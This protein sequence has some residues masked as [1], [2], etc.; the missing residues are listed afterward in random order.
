[1]S[2]VGD[3]MA[4]IIAHVLQHPDGL[5]APEVAIALGIDAGTARVYLQR[6]VDTGRLARIGRGTYAPSTPV[7]SVT[8]VT[9]EAPN[10]TLVT[11]VTPP[12]GQ[13]STCGTA[14]TRD[15]DLAAGQCPRCRL[16]EVDR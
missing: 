4:D 3:R 5:K 11:D 13:C 16:H 8:S 2:G 7:T 15:A 10:I 1:M 14:L 9:S 12:L 6:A